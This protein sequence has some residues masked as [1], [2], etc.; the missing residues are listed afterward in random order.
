VRRMAHAARLLAAAGLTV[1][2]SAAAQAN[3][4]VNGGFEDQVVT[5]SDKCDAFHYCRGYDPGV[6]DM[7]GWFTIGPGGI[8]SA[9]LLLNK[10]YTEL[11]ATSNATL[12]FTP[13]QGDNSV[14]L[15]GAGNQINNGADGIKQTVATK[16]GSSYTLSFAVGAQYDRAP[17][18]CCTSAIG[19]YIDGDFVATYTNRN[20]SVVDDL[21]WLTYDYTFIAS[22]DE[23]TVAF[24][25]ATPLGN[26]EAGLDGVD[27][28]LNIAEPSSLLVLAAGLLIVLAHPRR[29]FLPQTI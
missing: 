12:H 11:D 4:L 2:M 10:N 16:V 25:N 17:G 3:L 29:P 21:S 27:L 18:Y 8:D 19:L 24:L 28:S 7:P 13:F 1:A 6:S 23:T 22:T 15:T 20:D 14:D 5:Q 9:V 26:N